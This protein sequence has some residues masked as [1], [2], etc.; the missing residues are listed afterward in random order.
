MSSHP[1]LRYVNKLKI[2]RLLDSLQDCIVGSTVYTAFFVCM[3]FCR[4]SKALTLQSPIMDNLRWWSWHHNETWKIKNNCI[5]II[6]HVSGLHYL[7]YN[8]AWCNNHA[9]V[10]L[11]CEKVLENEYQI[12]KMQDKSKNNLVL[13]FV[14]RKKKMKWSASLFCCVA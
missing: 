10:W 4:N 1:S 11:S 8:G 3:P 2:F 6:I 7:A 5:Y 13:L 12:M 14:M 9:K